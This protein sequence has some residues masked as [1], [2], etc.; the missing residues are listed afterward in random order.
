MGLFV[1]ISPDWLVNETIHNIW[2]GF[3][4]YHNAG[5]D[6]FVYVTSGHGGLFLLRFSIIILILWGGWMGFCDVRSAR[7]SFTIHCL[8][9]LIFLYHNGIYPES[10]L[11][12]LFAT[13][14][15]TLSSMVMFDWGRTFFLL[16]GGHIFYSAPSSISELFFWPV[17]DGFLA[18]IPYS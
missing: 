4:I 6:R 13:L 15:F 18:A 3:L 10:I 2:I 9:F 17:S 1:V 5:R 7:S 11:F 8:L 14:C 16:C 12:F